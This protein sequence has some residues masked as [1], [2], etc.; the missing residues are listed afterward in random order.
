VS[1]RSLERFFDEWVYRPGHPSIKARVVWENHHVSVRFEQQQALA[2]ELTFS[3]D[4]VDA[5]GKVHRLQATSGERHFAL[6]LELRERPKHVVVDPDLFIVGSLR[7]EAPIDFIK[8]QLEHGAAPRA[9]R[10]A[11]RM[12]AGKRDYAA[13]ELLG[14]ALSKKRE[15]WMVRAG[16]ARALG[17]L[18]GTLGFEQ[19]TPHATVEAPKVR[20][21]VAEALGKFPTSASCDVLLAMLKTE[22]SYLVRSAIVRSLGKTRQPEMVA[23]VKGQLKQTSWGNIVTAAALESLSSLRDKSSVPLLVEHT[24]LGQPTR[25]RR[26]AASALAKLSDA[27]DVRETLADL[28]DDPHP[29]MR[30]DVVDALTYFGAAARPALERRL[31][32]EK[33]PRVLRRVKEVLRNIE[34][35]EPQRELKDK[36]EK[37]ER[38]LSEVLGRLSTLEG[39]LSKRKT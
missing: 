11:A 8:H 2:H 34:Q 25:V 27:R 28:L 6:A 18:G 16:A 29:H 9:R 31:S 35:G 1:G 36:V 22:K 23:K 13:A 15:S 37:L 32:R 26:S 14:K 4:V 33:D 20:A 39:T 24:R 7:I 19:L 5:H 21:A 38:S 30:S 10:Q 12:L 3:A 17:E